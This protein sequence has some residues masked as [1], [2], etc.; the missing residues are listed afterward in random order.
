[1]KAFDTDILTQ[2]MRGNPVFTERAAE[3]PVAEQSLPV[4]AAK[5]ILRGRLNAIRQAEAGKGKLTIEQAYEYFQ[6]ALLDLR[7]LPLLSYNAHAETQYE[8]WR[9]RKLRGSTHD[10]RIAAIC[11]VHSATLVTRNCRDF[12]HIPG[13][14]VEFWE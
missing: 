8:T 12:E 3:V 2:I 9:A 10:L 11:I 7:E 4:V 6:L 5:E 1:M 14:V 13:L